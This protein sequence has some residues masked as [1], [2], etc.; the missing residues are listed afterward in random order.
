L[1]VPVRSHWR[2]SS[3]DGTFALVVKAALG[4]G[5]SSMS[6]SDSAEGTGGNSSMESVTLSGNVSA[7]ESETWR[8]SISSSWLSS[9]SGGKLQHDDD[10]STSDGND[11]PDM[12]TMNLYYYYYY[13]YYC[14]Y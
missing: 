1:L 2:I 5:Q 11:G 12:L 10:S 3:G 6:I 14:Y 13:Y 7:S 8:S 4:L 9:I